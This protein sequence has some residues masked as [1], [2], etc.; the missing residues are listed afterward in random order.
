MQVVDLLLRGVVN[1]IPP[2][3]CALWRF[4]PDIP[5]VLRGLADCECHPTNHDWF[6][7][8]TWLMEIRVWPA[9]GSHAVEVC[10]H[11]L[12]AATTIDEANDCHAA[13]A[14]A[15]W[16]WSSTSRAGW[17]SRFR[18]PESLPP[19][20]RCMRWAQEVHP[21]GVTLQNVPAEVVFVQDAPWYPRYTAGGGLV[22]AD[23][24][25]GWHQ[26]YRVP[27]PVHADG[28]SQ[29]EHYVAWEVL[30][31]RGT[32]R[33]VWGTRGSQWSFHDSKGYIDAVQS[34]NPGPSPRSDDL[35]RACRGLLS[36]GFSAPQHLYSHRP[37]TFLDALLDVADREAKKQASGAR[38]EVG[39]NR[40]LQTPQVCFTHNDVQVH[41]LDCLVE[42]SSRRLWELDTEAPE[43][44]ER[45]SLGVY[46]AVT[47]LRLIR[48]GAHLRTM[49][50]W[51]S[52]GF[53]GDE[54]PCP[55]CYQTVGARHWVSTCPWRHLFWLPVHTQLH[56]RLDTL[57]AR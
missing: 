34:R 27:I 35:L 26:T 30:R 40:G 10:K 39:W 54:R 19:W 22:V 12:G 11:P 5:C 8:Y 41:N 29:A 3:V 57:C 46:A 28:S 49:A 25:T 48:W 43:Q 51:D 17:A 56:I 9:P 23:P 42:T 31:A 24:T 7:R 14:A 38:P 13:L 16:D 4:H 33:V 37:G 44:V 21:E 2:H 52:L 1:N 20:P 45:R 32:H 55:A 36:E 47:K 18:G 50:R 6:L 15:Y 53:A